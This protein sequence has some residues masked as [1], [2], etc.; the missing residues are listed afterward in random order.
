MVYLQTKE[1]FSWLADNN[2]L[3]EMRMHSNR[4]VFYKGQKNTIK[5]IKQLIPKG[6]HMARTIKVLWHNIPL[7]ITA[8][9]RIDKHGN[10]TIV[11][12][13]ATYKDKPSNHVKAYKK[14]WGIEKNVSNNQAAS[15]LKRLLFA[16]KSIANETIFFLFSM[17]MRFFNLKEKNEN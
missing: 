13:A 15:W 4:V 7:Y 2:I 11:Y 3:A 8:Q 1:L 10:E 12:Q 14:R 17:P 9:R 16:K 5:N 6:R